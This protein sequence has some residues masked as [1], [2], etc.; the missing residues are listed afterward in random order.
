M[1]RL[2]VSFVFAHLLLV[3]LVVVSFPDNSEGAMPDRILATVNN[4]VITLTDYQRFLKYIGVS[5]TGDGIDE[6]LLKQLIEEKVILYEAKRRGIEISDGEVD[7]MMEKMRAEHVLSADEMEKEL[8]AEGIGVQGFR[9]M[10]KEKLLALKL[11]ESEVDSRVRVSEKEIED[12]YHAN[13][14]DYLKSPG[15]VEVRAI[16]LKLSEGAT[17]SEITDL[18]RKGLTIMAQLDEGVSFEHLVDEYDDGYL[19]NNQGRFGEFERGALIPLLDNKV[20]SMDVGE[21]SQPIWVK[22]GVYI[23]RVV[24]KTADTYKSV[25]EVKEDIRAYL[26]GK[27]EGNCCM[28][29]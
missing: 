21:T 11:V 4:E 19:K 7:G 18:K 2:P 27:R 6:G 26:S 9:K 17:V 16:F 14:R 29:G 23:L 28:R 3:I 22:E 20:F 24:N 25:E 5:N 8:E 10:L 1:R 13:K 15:K 12:Y